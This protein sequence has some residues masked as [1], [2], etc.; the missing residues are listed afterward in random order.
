MTDDERTPAL[1]AQHAGLLTQVMSQTLDADYVTVAA[2]RRDGAPEPGRRS[3]LSLV[4]VLA[5]FGLMV[6][7]SA[8]Q[9]E[10]EKPAAAAERSDLVTQI[11]HRQSQLDALQSDLNDLGGQ[12]TILQEQVADAA[13]SGGD[14]AERLTALGIDS[15]ALAVT[16]PGVQIAVDDAPDADSGT[17]GTILDTDLQELVNG[18]W[19]AGAEAISIDGHRLTSLTSIRFA[20]SAIT[21]D[22]RSLTPPYTIV[23]TGDPD[24][25]PARL[26]ETAGGQKWIGLRA[27]FGIRF[28]VTPK[29]QVTVAADPHDHLLYATAVGAR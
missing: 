29:D 5:G 9:T 15:G 17:G 14:L 28:E 12:V 22:Y 20:G 10:Q 11:H 7:V 13:S 6:G 26:M 21:V 24:S 4:A 23:A 8:V 19:V 3:H 2:R 25:L 27:N 18:L 16:G 1:P